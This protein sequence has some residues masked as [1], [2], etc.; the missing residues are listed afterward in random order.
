MMLKKRSRPVLKDQSKGYLMSH[1]TS[2]G[3]VKKSST[4]SFLSV[5][6]LLVGFTSKGSSDCDAVWSPTSPLDKVFSS[7]GNS[8]LG[9]PT[10]G[11]SNGRLK[12]WDSSRVGLGLVDS[13][14]DDDENKPCGKALGNRN[15]VFG[16]QIKF[17]ISIPKPCGISSQQNFVSSKF[18]SNSSGLGLESKEAKLQNEEFV[19]LQSCSVD[20]GR[21]SLLLTKSFCNSS[22]N[23]QS[24][25]QSDS[26]NS[27]FGSTLAKGNANFEK[28][29]GSLPISLDSSHWL[30]S[31]L[32]ASEIEQSEDYTCIISHGPNPKKTHIFGDCILESH[33]IESPSFK[34]TDRKEEKGCTWPPKLPENS[35]SC[36]SCKKKSEEG[37][38][39]FV[40]S[41][42][43]REKMK[44]PS[45][46]LAG[47]PGSSF[48]EETLLDEMALASWD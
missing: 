40:H 46:F 25:V 47:S 1:S 32:S 44:K 12:C 19:L 27:V 42:Q 36:S 9:S 45:I 18:H 31:T 14:K 16:S 38:D 22:S 13:L 33:N 29:L 37:K 7:R 17:N 35:V 15:I 41:D 6:G 20:T 48:N 30:L 34:K 39:I 43:E 11:S 23:L 21:L 4:S 26:M 24:E 3:V 2:D 5:P 10:P 8:N 28:L